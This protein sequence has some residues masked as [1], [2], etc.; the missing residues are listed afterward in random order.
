MPNLINCHGI[1]GAHSM[2]DKLT[3]PCIAI[4][5]QIRHAF[6]F[7]TQYYACF[8]ISGNCNWVIY[9]EVCIATC[10]AI[11]LSNSIGTLIGII[12]GRWY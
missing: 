6:L 3:K 8:L 9:T 7:I 2:L 10:V 4:S 12:G 1:Q 5:S 11:Y